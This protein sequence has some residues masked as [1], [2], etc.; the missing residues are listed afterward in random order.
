VLPQNVDKENIGAK[1]RN[2]LLILE[3]RKRKEDKSRSIEVK[4]E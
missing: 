4:V 3:M 2:G 1:F